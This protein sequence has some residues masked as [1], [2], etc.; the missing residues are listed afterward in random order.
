M[1]FIVIIGNLEKRVFGMVNGNIYEWWFLS[2]RLRSWEYVGR[3][4]IL[5]VLMG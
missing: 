1:W 5:F 4:L 2:G 3:V